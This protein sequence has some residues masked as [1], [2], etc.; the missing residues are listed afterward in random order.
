MTAQK[1]YIAFYFILQKVTTSC[2]FIYNRKHRKSVFYIYA[3]LQAPK[4]IE[5]K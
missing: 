2:Q 1:T 3:F 5:T 4:S